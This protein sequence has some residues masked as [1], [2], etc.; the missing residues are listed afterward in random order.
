[1]HANMDNS[2]PPVVLA[3]VAHPDDIEFLF[4][5]TLLLLK[6]AGCDVHFWNL[7]NGCLGSL[8]HPPEELARLRLAE[9]GESARLAGATLHPPLFDD[10]AVFYDAPS[11]A[12]VASVVRAVRPQILLTHSMQDYMEDHQNVAR[13][14]VSAAFSRGMPGYRTDPPE[15]AASDPLRIY[16]AAPHGLHNGMG[17]PFVADFLVDIASVIETKE[18]LLG[19]HRSQKDWLEATQGMGAYTME[20]REMGRQQAGVGR[21]LEL[22]EGWRRHLHLGFCP[23]DFDPLPRTLPSFIQNLNLR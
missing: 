4:A 15:A 17:E 3:A 10:L 11:L 16:H 13:L 20:M 5:G 18:R 19:C 21:N 8:V 7:A 1:M 2:R 12:R 22:A 14:I 9:A 6:D 23:P